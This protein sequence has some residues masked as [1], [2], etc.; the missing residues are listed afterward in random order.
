MA[1]TPW[2]TSDD[3]IEA[4]TRKISIPIYQT[5][6]TPEDILSH[7]NEE[8]FIAQVPSMLQ[9]H[10]EYF[11]TTTEVPLENNRSNYPIP[12]RAI[13]LRLR[14]LF[15]KDTNGNFF[16]MT[17]IS[18]DDRAFFERT[19]ASEVSLHKFFMQGNDIVLIPTLLT[20]PTGS[21]VFVY[22]L[23]PNQLVR[24]DQAAIITAFTKTI[25]IDNATIV[26]GSE[27][28]IDGTIFEAVSSGPTGNQFLIGGSSTQTATSLTN[29]I[30]TNG[31][32]IADNG[33]P[34]SS[35]ILISY[36][37]RKSS[38][39]SIGTGIT[40]SITQGIEFESIPTNI[41]DGALID[42]L[43][44]KP[45]HRTKGLSVKIGLNGIT[46]NVVI[47]FNDSDVPSD[48]IVGD[49]ICLENECIIPQIPPDLHNAL[50]E[51]VCA[52]VLA[53]IG[54]QAGAQMVNQ[55][56]QDIETRQGNLLDNRI[57]GSPQKIL[58]KHSLLRYNSTTFRRR[59]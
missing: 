25:V 9:Y 32:A 18:P 23:R 27:L 4:V 21:L 3:I 28:V 1:K 22:Y 14:D 11:V 38:I 43:Q 40:I 57:E 52:R 2:M 58:N 30:N 10:E 54:D 56:L 36:Q 49:Y 50:A 41:T 35:T 24:N 8:M 42:F 12:D 34:S 26:A 5:T 59:F 48:L 53:S 29:I 47:G 51:R 45:G 46:N 6:V 20:N 7:A 39:T 15:Y 44:T 17:R 13:G 37:N 19:A 31:I 16:E 55:K 33:S